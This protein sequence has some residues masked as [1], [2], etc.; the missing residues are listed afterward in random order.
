[1]NENGGIARPSVGGIMGRVSVRTIVTL[2]AAVAL[3]APLLGCIVQ[4]SIVVQ[5][6]GQTVTANLDYDP[7]QNKYYYYYFD[8]VTGQRK[9]VSAE[10]FEQGNVRTPGEVEETK[11]LAA[12][13]RALYDAW[14]ERA[15]RESE[16][17]EKSQQQA[18]PGS[19]A[20]QQLRETAV[21]VQVMFAKIRECLGG[22]GSGARQ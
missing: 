11:R 18:Y 20:G 17:R 3:T 8:P 6:R 1:M 15:R 19:V 22:N 7:Y 5:T 4:N 16:A 10:Y 12:Q 14:A 13:T 2:I 21:D 9:R